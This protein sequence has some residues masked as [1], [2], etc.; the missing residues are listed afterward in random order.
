MKQVANFALGIVVGCVAASMVVHRRVIDA[1][2]KGEPIPEPP[3][4]H[5]KYHPFFAKSE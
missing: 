4:W 3:E 1:V 2:L 5:K